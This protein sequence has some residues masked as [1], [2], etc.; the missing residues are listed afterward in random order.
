MELIQ[1]LAY[2]QQGYRVFRHKT[3]PRFRI[4]TGEKTP[5]GYGQDRYRYKL[6]D[7]EGNDPDKKTVFAPNDLSKQRWKE[8]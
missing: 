2:K 5:V 7:Y 3:Q 1:A 4:Y 6:I 8:L